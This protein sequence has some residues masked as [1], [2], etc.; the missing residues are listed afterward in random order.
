M[1]LQHQNGT[2]LSPSSSSALP[3]TEAE[4]LQNSHQGMN[5]AVPNH[6]LPPADHLQQQ[7]KQPTDPSMIIPA[8]A[9][10]DS[11]P[12]VA[13]L[14]PSG[15]IYNFGQSPDAL[16]GPRQRVSD[17]LFSGDSQRDSNSVQGDPV[18]GP[19]AP[20]KSPPSSAPAGNS[21][22]GTVSSDPS[23]NFVPR[24]PLDSPPPPPVDFL[25]PQPLPPQPQQKP[26]AQEEIA[27]AP[28]ES[29]SA[30]AAAV[31]ALS[32][33]PVAMV[34][35]V[36]AAAAAV[37]EEVKSEHGRLN[38]A[39]L[40]SD[41]RA[42]CDPYTVVTEGWLLKKNPHQYFFKRNWRRR[43]YRLYPGH[44][45]WWKSDKDTVKQPH[46]SLPI[47]AIKFAHMCRGHRER[48]EGRFDVCVGDIDIQR[49]FGLRAE[50]DEMAQRWVD[51]ITFFVQL[52]GGKKSALEDE[53]MTDRIF[54]K[55]KQVRNMQLGDTPLPQKKQ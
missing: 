51:D 8:A 42:E 55:T 15:S 54:W 2:S 4:I 11:P 35:P 5:G 48:K 10:P 45:R 13:P 14:K 49:V 9:A 39:D 34:A 33:P 24:P 22:D 12:E 36:P 16:E 25:S 7:Q 41:P 47:G 17:P 26:A 29:P 23:Q 44:L 37:G 30:A 27:V 19:G 31:A 43:Y 18:L 52:N 1:H 50:S 46:G 32:V 40:N 53:M 21:V 38:S 20:V 28:E 6:T 3:Q